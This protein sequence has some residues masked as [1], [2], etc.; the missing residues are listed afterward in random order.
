MDFWIKDQPRSH[1][2]YLYATNLLNNS[3]FKPFYWLCINWKIEKLYIHIIHKINLQRALK[4]SQMVTNLRKMY[5]KNLIG[6]V[7][8]KTH[9]FVFENLLAFADKM[10]FKFSGQNCCFFPWSF[11]RGPHVRD[12][13]NLTN[14]NPYWRF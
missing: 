12:G 3:S 4:I 5:L 9:V 11:T 6:P 14:T 13:W 7:L 2:T 10:R 8:N 1:Q